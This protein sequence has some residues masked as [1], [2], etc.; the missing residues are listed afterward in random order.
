MRSITTWRR[1]H[2]V[3]H[4]DIDFHAVLEVFVLGNQSI[5]LAVFEADTS[6]HVRTGV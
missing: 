1:G 3:D 4:A 2:L 5:A 6:G